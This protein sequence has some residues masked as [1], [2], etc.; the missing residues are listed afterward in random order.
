M[1]PIGSNASNHYFRDYQLWLREN[2]ED[3]TERL[4]R[5][6]RNL[7]T[8]R[9]EELTPLQQRVFRMFYEEGLSVSEIARREGRNKSS[10][11]RAIKR[12]HARL[13]NHLRYSL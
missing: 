11:S 7:R 6:R 3:N 10:V 12:G 1:K 5:M 4:E 13:Q 9:E 8:A 2:A